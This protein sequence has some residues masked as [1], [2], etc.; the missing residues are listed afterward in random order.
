[1]QIPNERAAGDLFDS[2]SEKGRALLMG[3]AM[4]DN[5]ALTELREACTGIP[6][7]DRGITLQEK[8]AATGTASLQGA[9]SGIISRYMMVHAANATPTR[10]P[11]A[12]PIYR[13][14][15]AVLQRLILQ[16]DDLK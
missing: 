9:P 2:Q 16:L 5:P 12:K 6:A 13:G 8:Q 14:L 15:Q 11:L 10:L 1:M 3:L 7:F 4:K